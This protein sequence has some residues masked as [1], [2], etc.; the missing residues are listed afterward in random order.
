MAGRPPTNDEITRSLTMVRIEFMIPD[1]EQSGDLL[2]DQ[3]QAVL[4]AMEEARPHLGA[5]VTARIMAVDRSGDV[6]WSPSYEP[7]VML[8][9]WDTST[10]DACPECG[11][12]IT[13]LEPLWHWCRRDGARCYCSQ[14]CLRRAMV[15][16]AD[17]CPRGGEA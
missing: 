8:S 16:A 4:L 15:A 10:L 7:L 1:P 14:E 5:H 3:I 13:Q 2:R 12:D 17:P 11:V 9:T 6:W